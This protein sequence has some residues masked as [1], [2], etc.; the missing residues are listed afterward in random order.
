MKELASNALDLNTSYPGFIYN[1]DINSQTADVQLAI[2]SLYVGLDSSY[3]TI[4]KDRLKDVPVQVIRGGGWSLTFPVPDGT[5]CYVEFSQ[6]GIEHWLMEGKDSAGLIN[7]LPAPQFN[8]TFQANNAVATIGINPVTEN[9]KSYQNNVAEFRNIDRSQRVTLH[10]NGVIEIL[11]GSA[12]IKVNKDG[13]IT[14][15]SD[16]EAIVKAPKI[17]LDGD[18]EVTKTLTVMGQSNLNGGVNIRTGSGA[19]SA[20]NIDGKMAITSTINGVQV[21]LHQ[22]DYYWKDNGGNDRTAPPSKV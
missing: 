2:E 20:I 15:T 9:I 19:N 12:V 21:E 16:T 1:F 7:G 22:H 14:A 17:K 11:S 4:K 10:D 13:D 8:Q 5:P 18:T 3:Q 6:R